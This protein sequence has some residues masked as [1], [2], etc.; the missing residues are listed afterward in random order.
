[1]LPANKRTHFTLSNVKDIW[2]GKIQSDRHDTFKAGGRPARDLIFYTI[3][4]REL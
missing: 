2:S 1:M 3:L 4:G